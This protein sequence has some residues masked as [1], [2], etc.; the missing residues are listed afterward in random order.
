MNNAI[1]EL[2]TIHVESRPRLDGRQGF[3]VCSTFYHVNGALVRQLMG[4]IVPAL[5]WKRGISWSDRQ[6]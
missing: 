4:V 5:A 6:F 2:F 1:A 3:R